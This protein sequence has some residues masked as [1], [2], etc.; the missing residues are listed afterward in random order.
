MQLQKE[1]KREEKKRKESAGHSSAE[2]TGSDREER[3]TYQS[4][5][6]NKSSDQYATK[7]SQKPKPAV[8]QRPRRTQDAIKVSFQHGLETISYQITLGKSCFGRQ[9]LNG[10]TLPIRQVRMKSNFNLAGNSKS[11]HPCSTGKHS[12]RCWKL[13]YYLVFT[14]IT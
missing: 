14:G 7:I 1:Q 9:I 3:G 8:P 5:Y 2:S 4:G 10:P 13:Y 12:Y 11:R 6:N